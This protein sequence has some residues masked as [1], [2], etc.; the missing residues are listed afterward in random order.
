MGVFRTKVGVR[1]VMVLE[2]RRTT[3]RVDLGWA[4]RRKSSYSRLG[5]GMDNLPPI[6]LW[7]ASDLVV[8]CR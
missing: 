2:R 4:I 7:I 3:G 5:S 1:S 6:Q 8:L